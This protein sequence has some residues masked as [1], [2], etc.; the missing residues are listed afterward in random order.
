MVEKYHYI[1]I[2]EVDAKLAEVDPSVQQLFSFTLI[3]INKTSRITKQLS[4]AKLLVRVTSSSFVLVNSS[5]S[6]YL[7]EESGG[8]SHNNSHKQ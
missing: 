2:K 1:Y 4:E 6:S 5:C 7:E 8:N 3:S